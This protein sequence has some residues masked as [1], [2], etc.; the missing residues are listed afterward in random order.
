VPLEGDDRSAD[1]CWRY[2]L[3]YKGSNDFKWAYD[4][5]E[6]L[7]HIMNTAN[8]AVPNMM[9]DTNETV[10]TGDKQCT[11]PANRLETLCDS[12]VNYI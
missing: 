5:T 12:K 8:I 7:C 1:I 9:I 2:A 3:A 6:H 10:V 11:A 4:Y